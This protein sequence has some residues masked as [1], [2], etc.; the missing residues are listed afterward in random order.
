MPDTRRESELETNSS[1]F[2]EHSATPG[3]SSEM[4]PGATTVW[5]T[6][7]ELAKSR[8]I[9]RRSAERLAQRHRWPRRPGNDGTA[10]VGVPA[11]AEKPTERQ[12][13]DDRDADQGDAGGVI[14]SLRDAFATALGA[15]DGEI[16]ALQ[17]AIDA[18]EG[19]LAAYR[20]QIDAQRDRLDAAE[21]D[22]Q[23]ARQEA[24]A[25]RRADDVRKAR[26]R[27]ARLRAAWRGE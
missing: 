7:A 24:E 19:Q 8:G 9:S 26:R 10:R 12:Q 13:G 5:M 23:E 27:W 16:A 6:Y 25:L 17:A 3:A 11:G 22:A 4:A 1:M 2:S 18:K 14:A 15:R 20:G 21:R